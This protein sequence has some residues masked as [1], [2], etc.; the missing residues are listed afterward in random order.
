[1]SVVAPPDEKQALADDLAGAQALAEQGELKGALKLAERVRVR[2]LAAEDVLVLERVLELARGVYWQTEAAR[3]DEPELAWL[4]SGET[5]PREH[6]AAGRLAFGAQQNIRFVGR[7]R[8]LA[9]GREWVDPFGGTVALPEQ[10]PPVTIGNTI[11]GAGE[12]SLLGLVRSLLVSLLFCGFFA[13]GGAFGAETV[14]VWV[15]WAEGWAVYW[16]VMAVLQVWW[17]RKKYDQFWRPI[18]SWALTGFGAF[19]LGMPVM[20]LVAIFYPG[21]GSAQGV[22]IIIGWLGSLAVLLVCLPRLR[23]WLFRQ[24]KPYDQRP[25]QS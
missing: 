15:A 1:V 12:H 23:R 9:E 10:R 11:I 21:G 8:A 19:L 3:S 7:K 17:W 2:A 22:A 6:N 24:L 25:S 20:V 16:L 13:L 5:G 14:D 4:F 18:Y